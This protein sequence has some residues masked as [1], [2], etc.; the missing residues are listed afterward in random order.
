ML[1]AIPTLAL[2]DYDFRRP[3]LNN[4]LHMRVYLTSPEL[5]TDVGSQLMKL[6]IQI[7]EDGQVDLE[8]IKSLRRWLRTNQ[9]NEDVVAIPYLCDIMRR[10][11]ADGVISKDELTELHLAIERVIPK[12]H[13]AA[14]TNA[15][16][17][18]NQ[19]RRERRRLQRAEQQRRE[20]EHRR[21]ARD[22]ERNERLRIRHRIARVAGV[23]FPNADGTERQDVIASC[24]PGEQLVL[25]HD[26]G[27]E[28][29]EC[30][31]RVL[32]QN[33]TQLG[34]APEYLAEEIVER[35]SEGFV[36]LASLIDVLGGTD[37]FPTLGARIVVLYIAE[38]VP[39]ED[40]NA[41]ALRIEVE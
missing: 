6:C 20:R 7:T 27:N 12:S 4:G 30:A 37:Q 23:T 11:T 16:K 10:I 1:V 28:Y 17:K 38:G 40:V 14:A 3:V 19:E 32:R 31:V 34:Y 25:M 39:I 5:E 26:P 36:V 2:R 41:Y 9:R 33:G 13:R 24:E 8:E 15:R 29:S 21:T 22:Q 18:L 35:G